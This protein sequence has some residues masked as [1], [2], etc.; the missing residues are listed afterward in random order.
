[1]GLL[2]KRQMQKFTTVASFVNPWEAYIAKGRLEAEGLKA[3]I[4]HE[5]HIWVNWPISQALGG[6]KV[7]VLYEDKKTA[8]IVIKSHLQG[9][10]EIENNG[11]ETQVN[12]CPNCGS[13]AYK[14]KLPLALVVFAI[15]TLGLFTI[16]FP[17]R[18]TNHFCNN[19]EFQWQY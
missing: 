11:A 14:S 6:V 4:A 2:H 1:M 7:Q 13:S 5:H 18:R 17:L 12:K 3:F 8:E 19:C 15:L 9:E 10:Y 16:I